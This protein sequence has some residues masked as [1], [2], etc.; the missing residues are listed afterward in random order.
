[1]GL[2]SA[3]YLSGEH[4]EASRI[5]SVRDVI[6]KDEFITKLPFVASLPVSKTCLTDEQKQK[7][8]HYHRLIFISSLML[9]ILDDHNAA[10]INALRE[11]RLTA[12]EEKRHDIF[13]VLPDPSSFKDVA[14]L[15]DDLNTLS[16]TPN[17]KSPLS[18]KI[19]DDACS[20]QLIPDSKL[21]LFSAFAGG[22]P[23]L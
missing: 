19:I 11:W 23:S 3:T 5:T 21:S 15:R 22:I 20:G 8:A 14:L 4:G 6:I 13:D 16:S 12:E 17:K 10:I 9:W 2:G 1:M 18:N 7:Y